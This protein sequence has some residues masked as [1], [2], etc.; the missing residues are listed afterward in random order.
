MK[1]YNPDCIPANFTLLQ[2]SFFIIRIF[3][4]YLLKQKY[5]VNK[6][7]EEVL[8]YFFKNILCVIHMPLSLHPALKKAP[9]H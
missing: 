3:D 8:N 6:I 9:D 5:H 1:L 4:V 2:Y 7:Y